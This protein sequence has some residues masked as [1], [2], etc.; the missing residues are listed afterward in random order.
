MKI[1]QYCQHVLGVGHFFRSMAIAAAFNGH[2]VLFV[3]G[4]EPLVDFIP[5]SH[6]QRVFLPPI[7]MDSGFCRV[8][9]RRGNIDEIKAQRK[10][11]LEKAFRSF[12]PDVLIIELF[13]FGRKYFQFEL[14]PLLRA[15]RH[16]HAPVK[17]VCSLR[18]I[19]VEKKEQASYEERV[20]DTLNSYFDLLVIHS[21]PRL[22]PLNETFSRMNHIRI[23][24]EYTGF[25]VRTVPRA[26]SMQTGGLI[27]ASGG[28]S[29]VGTDLLA[30]AIR[31]VQILPDK[32]LKLRAFMSPFAEKDEQDHL[33]RL[34]AQGQQ[35]ILL[36]F[37]PDF[38]NELAGAALSISMA[39]YNTCMDILSSGVKALVYP[40]PQNQE[41]AMRAQKLRELGVL[42][43]LTSL[44]IEYLA[45][46][47]SVRLKEK[48]SNPSTGPILMDGAATTVHIV[49][50]YFS[51]P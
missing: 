9:T 37:S 44:E 14:L 6:V 21:D 49:E 27:V 45:A 20:L 41:Q 39:G 4:G 28:G 18:D 46:A 30:A 16:E 7:M 33:A 12:A 17:V 11:L 38:L 24:I 31:A 23:P 51:R 1:M 32:E 2:Q 47:I 26:T 29:R 10:S 13:P 22:A 50:K 25:V 43:I 34:A 36:P 19:L 15:I 3:E 48:G 42:E 40:F 5:P 35:T 8:E